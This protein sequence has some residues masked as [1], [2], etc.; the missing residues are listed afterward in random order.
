MLL[1]KHHAFRCCMAQPGLIHCRGPTISLG[2]TTVEATIRPAIDGNLAGGGL[3]EDI[4]TTAAVALV[5]GV[6]T[7]AMA[8]KAERNGRHGS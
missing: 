7:G 5:P 6:H 2:D 4:A 3:V 1:L 8:C